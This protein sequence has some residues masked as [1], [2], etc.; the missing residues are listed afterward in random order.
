MAADQ[1]DQIDE[2][3]VLQSSAN[4]NT[5]SHTIKKG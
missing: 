1:D 3:D 4:S 2:R 5:E